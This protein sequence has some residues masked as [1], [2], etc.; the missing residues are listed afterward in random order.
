MI[1]RSPTETENCA[2]RWSFTPSARAAWELILRSSQFG[3][4]RSVILPGY[5]GLSPHEGSGLFDPIRNSRTPF[6]FY[7]LGPKLQI[8]LDL[9]EEHLSTRKHPVLL[10][11]HYFGFPHVNMAELKS[12]CQRY[13]TILVEDCAHV[14]GPLGE[15]TGLGTYGDMAFYSLHKMLPVKYGGVLCVNSEHLRVPKRGEGEVGPE[16]L[17]QLLRADWKEISRVRRVNY[18]YLRTELEAIEGLEIVYDL[19]TDVVPHDFPVIIENGKR[20]ALYFALMDQGLPTTSLYHQMIPEILPTEH[21]NSHTLSRSI[22]N[23][24]VHQ[25]TTLDDLWELSTA[26]KSIMNNLFG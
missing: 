3:P 20:E 7:R 19:P 6:S 5:I 13:D 15:A 18:N 22:L 21:P 8:D 23:L 14:P 12:L 9:I 26:I 10:V 17:S 25:D 11:A 16:I 1:Q 24:P 4:D 2:F